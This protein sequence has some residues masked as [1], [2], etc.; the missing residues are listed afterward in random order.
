MTA[1]FDFGGWLNN[2]ENDSIEEI[3]S[4]YLSIEL[5]ATVGQYTSRLDAEKGH[6]WVSSNNPIDLL[7]LSSNAEK[8]FLDMLD[9][10]YKGE[11]RSVKERYEATTNDNG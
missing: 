5:Q 8:A 3:H 1:P 7:L 9:Q 2:L 6:I 4:L 11:F 10:R